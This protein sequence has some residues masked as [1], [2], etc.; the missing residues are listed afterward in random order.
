[1]SALTIEGANRFVCLACGAVSQGNP[2]AEVVLQYGK[3]AFTNGASNLVIAKQ[4]AEAVVREVRRDDEIVVKLIQKALEWA[5]IDIAACL[6][7]DLG[8]GR[9]NRKPL[10]FVLP[11]FGGREPPAS[12]MAGIVSVDFS[13]TVEANGNGVVDGMV[14]AVGSG[15]DVIYFYLGP[16]ESVANATASVAPD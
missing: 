6:Y 3:D 5:D 12:G 9:T 2:A 10:L 1:M 13:M 15:N 16:A 11:E 4:E 14:L 7:K 8:A